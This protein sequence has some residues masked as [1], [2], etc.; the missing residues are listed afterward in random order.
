MLWLKFEIS[1]LVNRGEKDNTL[2]N[3]YVLFNPGNS[4]IFSIAEANCFQCMFCF[5]KTEDAMCFGMNSTIIQDHNMKQTTT[6][7]FKI[8][9]L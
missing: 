7:Y 9:S 3:I 1:D 5:V 4:N 2:A 8:L 6:H